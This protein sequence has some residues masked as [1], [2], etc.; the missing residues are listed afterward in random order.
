LGRLSEARRAW[1]RSREILLTV[2][3]FALVAFTFLD[4]LRDVALT[5]GAAEPAARRQLAAEAEEALGRA[6]G[7]LR[8]GLSPLLARLGCLVLDGR[9]DEANRILRDLPA[10]GNCYLRRETTAAQVTL[11]RHRG[12]PEAAWKQIDAL[13]P[14]GPATEPGDVIHQEGLFLQRLAADLC[15]DAGDLPG[16]RAWLDAHDRWLAWS[17]SE[18]GRADGRLVWTRYH[19]ATGD[20]GRA[21]EDA[22]D[23]LAQAARPDQPLVRLVAHR[24]LGEIDTE[25][26]HHAVAET[27]LSIAFDLAHTCEAPFERALTLLALAE[28]RAASGETG[29]ATRLLDDVRRICAPLGAA[30]T[31]ARVDALGARL[32]STPQTKTIPFG[33]TQRELDVLRLL[34][35]GRSNPEIAEALF[36]SRDTARTHVA[37]I[38]RKLDVGTR[39]EAVDRA[40]RHGLLSPSPPSRT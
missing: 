37:N 29:E 32:A 2:D 15:L 10:P 24:L 12:Q 22:G 40:H 34:V 30:P 19:R 27:H 4:E 3:H 39:A 28:L 23:A 14:D 35:A 5:Y 9:W 6:G 18:L 25:S 21:R 7:A 36:I 1:A 31:L 38:F 33:L 17:G 20:A 11:A 26:A 8:P 16:A 13:L